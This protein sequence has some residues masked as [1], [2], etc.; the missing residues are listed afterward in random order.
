MCRFGCKLQRSE[1][2]EGTHMY[3]LAVT[4]GVADYDKWKAEYDAMPP[5]GEGAKFARVNRNVDDPNRIAV[6]SGFESLDALR[7]FIG[8][9]RLKDAMQRA[10][11]LGEP[12][13]EIYEEVEV[14]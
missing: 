13:I 2:I 9:P 7:A 8:D 6:V 11:V 5:T 12:R 10:G 3:V 14:I 4:H 1:A